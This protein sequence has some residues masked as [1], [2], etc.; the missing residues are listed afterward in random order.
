MSLFSNFLE[1]ARS[2]TLEFVD[3]FK[4][5]SAQLQKEIG[6]QLEAISHK[7][8]V[9]VVGGA[10]N[11]KRDGGAVEGLEGEENDE[12]EAGLAEEGERE[13]IIEQNQNLN[14]DVEEH[15]E[16]A[17][18]VLLEK[19][20]H[21]VVLQL[22]ESYLPDIKKGEENHTKS[23][24]TARSR[25]GLP[26]ASASSSGEPAS[27]GLGK[28]DADEVNIA[29]TADHRGAPAPGE[30][31]I[32]ILEPQLSWSSSAFSRGT[33]S[34]IIS[35]TRTVLLERIKERIADLQ[36]SDAT[37]L[38]PLSADEDE[39]FNVNF[40]QNGNGNGSLESSLRHLKGDNLLEALISTWEKN[41]VVSAKFRTLILAAEI[42]L[43]SRDEFWRRY[44]YRLNR[45]RLQE[46]ARCGLEVGYNG[47][48][49]DK[50]FSPA[51][52]SVDATCLDNVVDLGNNGD[53]DIPEVLT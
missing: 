18:P 50:L 51:T 46:Q 48:E 28:N 53:A 20:D 9:P 49:L 39:E 21:L 38:D 41:P 10:N 31:G 12:K 6:N 8:P 35:S 52:T 42:P 5:E 14:C 17:G 24:Q 36:H 30:K 47:V 44:L 29:K 32:K 2:H 15:Q 37:Y 7:L 19:E 4:E 43:A 11:G 40:L 22:P 33:S 3:S 16:S 1:T 26:D 13:G 27:A 45:L 34:P 25:N 23:P